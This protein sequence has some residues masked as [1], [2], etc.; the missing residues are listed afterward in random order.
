MSP[1]CGGDVCPWHRQC[2]WCPP[3]PGSRWM[4]RQRR[5]CGF[6]TLTRHVARLALAWQTCHCPALRCL[7]P[8]CL[9]WWMPRRP[10]GL[11][12][13]R[14]R[15][16]GRSAPAHGALPSAGLK[17]ETENTR[18]LL[19]RVQAPALGLGRSRRPADPRLQAQLPLVL[20]PTPVQEPGGGRGASCT[21]T[22]CLPRGC[23]RSGSG[24][25]RRAPATWTEPH[26][27][28]VAA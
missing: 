26:P 23:R 28:L 4:R 13:C 19:L 12:R 5:K 9:S 27:P 20:A 10:R 22:A 25:P 2:G 21:A 17:G 16:M 3:C 18:R 15:Q 6:V 11:S 7:K 8:G 1:C 24:D 14:V